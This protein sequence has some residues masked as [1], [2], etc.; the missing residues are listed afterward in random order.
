MDDGHL[1]QRS[2]KFRIVRSLSFKSNGAVLFSLKFKG[3]GDV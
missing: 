3:L 1:K 2:T